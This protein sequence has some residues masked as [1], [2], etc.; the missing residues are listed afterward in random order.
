VS[1][2]SC[3]FPNEE[4]GFGEDIAALSVLDESVV[5]LTPAI[6]YAVWLLPGLAD[7]CRISQLQRRPL[8]QSAE[9]EAAW[10]MMMIEVKKRWAMSE[11]PKK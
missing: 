6:S 11:V 9:L 8:A 5:G 2:L 7:S 10:E 3:N 4:Q 1:Q